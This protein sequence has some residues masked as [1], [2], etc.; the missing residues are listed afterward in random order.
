MPS[1]DARSTNSEGFEMS[2]LPANA[3]ATPTRTQPS[4]II[5]AA[6]RKAVEDREIAGVVAIA[7]ERQRVLY[8]GCFGAADIARRRPLSADAVFNVAS[9]TERGVY[10]A[11]AA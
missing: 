4:K 5:D 9:M 10:Q 7:V 1:L 8:Q 11:A 3:R 2:D 6:L